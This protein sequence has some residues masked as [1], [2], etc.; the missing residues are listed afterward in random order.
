MEKSWEFNITIHQLFVD[1]KQAYDSLDRNVFFS[2]MEEFCIPMKLTRLTKATLMDTKC[3]ILI[4]NSPLDPFDIDTGFKQGDRL[5]TLLFNLAL[6]KVARAMSINWNGTILNT[7]KQL[8]AFADDTDLLGRG[9]L[10]VQESFVE[11]DMEARKVGLVVSED[12]TKYMVLDRSH[13]TRIG[14]NLTMNEYNFEVVQSFKYLGSIVNVANDL[15]EELKT[16]TIQDNRCFYALK[17]LF[18]SNEVSTIQN[19]SQDCCYICQQN[20]HFDIKSGKQ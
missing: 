12:K 13:G 8:T 9:I 2:I 3:R 19:I 6:E 10:K 15:D 1:F 5:S 18:R 7:S 14:Q 16:R 4:Q 11:M 20:L 17:H